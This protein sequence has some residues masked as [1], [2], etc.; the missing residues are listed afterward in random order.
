MNGADDG[1]GSNGD[2]K[3][4]RQEATE[5]AEEVER[6]DQEASYGYVSENDVIAVEAGG[7]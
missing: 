5:E 3:Q 6:V 7:L 4:R 1:L 2:R